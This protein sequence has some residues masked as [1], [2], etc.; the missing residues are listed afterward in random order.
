V[1]VLLQIFP[2]IVTVKIFDSFKIS[3]YLMKL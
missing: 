2:M 1:T 3:Q